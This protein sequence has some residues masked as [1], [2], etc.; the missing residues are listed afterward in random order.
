MRTLDG[1]RIGIAALS[2]GVLSLLLALDE[3]S[4]RGWTDPLILGLFALGAAGLVAFAL[5]EAF[6][7]P[8]ARGRT[9]FSVARPAASCAVRSIVKSVVPPS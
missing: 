6:D 1:G 3:G 2:V 5:I 9:C 8:P 4:D 7:V